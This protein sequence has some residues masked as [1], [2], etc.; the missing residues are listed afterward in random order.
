MKFVVY[1]L[2]SLLSL[3][4]FSAAQNWSLGYSTYLG[5]PGWRLVRR[6]GGGIATVA[7]LGSLAFAQGQVSFLQHSTSQPTVS[8]WLT[9]TSTE[10]ENWILPL[11]GRCSWATVVA[12]SS[13]P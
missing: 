1:S 10:T 4:D 2:L 8:I 5:V 12:P 9:P 13:R 6:I 3:A 11:R 7:L